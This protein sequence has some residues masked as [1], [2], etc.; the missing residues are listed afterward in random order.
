MFTNLIESQSHVREFKRRSSFFLITV[1]GYAIALTGAGV[2]SVFAYDAQLEAQSSSLELMSWVPPVTPEPP[3]PI[4]EVRP[5]PVR[6]TPPSAPVD[7]NASRPMRTDFVSRPD[8]PSRVPDKVG[9][10]ASA[11]P[12]ITH[13]A[14][15]GTRNVDPPAAATSNSGDCIACPATPAVVRVIDTPPAP[16]PPKPTTRRVPSE[17]LNSK[18][19]SA[20]QPLYPAMAKQTRTQGSVNIQ[21]LVDEQGKVVSAQVMSG[22]PMLTPAAREAAMRA[23]FTPTTLNGVPVKIQG[24]ITYNFR[25]Q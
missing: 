16:E 21:I 7:P 4:N 10:Q 8:D 23:R 12:P 19:I 14:V 24:V 18:L 17:V 22:N 20:P 6:H 1:V 5:Q 3:R 25:L 13:G 2:A 11:I 15:L 9:T